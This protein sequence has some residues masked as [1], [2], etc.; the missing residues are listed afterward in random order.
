[1]TSTEKD[2]LVARLRGE[3]LAGKLAPGERLPRETE[4]S[5]RYHVSRNTAREA[6]SA[7][8]AQGLIRTRRGMSGGTFVSVPGVGEVADSLDV[9]LQLWLRDERLAPTDL[10]TVRGL[11]EAQAVSEGLAG[12]GDSQ[13]DL[14]R[15]AVVAITQDRGRRSP[16]GGHRGPGSGAAPDIHQLLVA[17]TGNP[18]LVLLHRAAALALDP[19]LA[20]A[21]GTAVADGPEVRDAVDADH[22]ALITHLEAGDLDAVHTVSRAHLD[23]F[24]GLLV[25]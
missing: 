24:A 18:M 22:A 6:I 11:V 13:R 7:L 9:V 14:L 2:R 25:A 5:E 16:C 12:L 15:A 10:L 8:S 23:R 21:F 17:A 20:D 1:M 3:I 4:L 19:F